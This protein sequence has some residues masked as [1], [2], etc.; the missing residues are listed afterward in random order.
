MSTSILRRHAPRLTAV[1]VIG[2]AYLMTRLPSLAHT[3][4]SALADRFAFT[5]L[6]LPEVPGPERRDRR[7]VH[8][9]LA[10][11]VGW[12]S[13]VGA[14]VALNDF[15]GD[16]LANDLCY[17]E[18]ATDQVIVAPAPGTGDR[19]A[20]FVIESLALR[21]ARHGTRPERE[22]VVAPMGCLGGDFNE[23]GRTDVLVWYWG[24][25]PVAFLRRAG[26]PAPAAS[27]YAAIDVVPRGAA[28][29]DAR[30]WYTNAATTADVDGDGHVDLVIGNYFADGARV[31]DPDAEGVEEMQDSMSRA[32]NGGRDRILLFA[33][34]T[35]GAEPT[36]SFTDAADAFEAPVGRGWT[37]AVGA[38]DLDGDLLPELYFAND[39]GPDRLLHNLSEPGKVRFA[40]LTGRKTIAMPTSKVLG[41]DS[42]KGMGVDF[43]D[44]NDDGLLDI[45]V[46]N[47]AEEF[48][49]EESHFLFASTGRTDLMAAGVAPY[50]DRS[51]ALGVSRSGWG[52]DTRFGDFDNDGVTEMVQATGFLRGEHDRWPELHE[53]AMANDGV[54]RHASSWP[55]FDHGDDLSGWQHNPFFVRAQDGRYYDIAPD[56][57]LGA[58]YLTRGIATADVDGDGDLD[59]AIANQWE[60]SYL[61]R[62]ESAATGASLG[63]DLRIP[64][65]DAS[66]GRPAIGAAVTVRRPDGRALVAQVD[67]GNGHSGARSPEL[68]FGLGALPAGETVMVEV[69]WRDGA[70]GIR[71]RS[72][73]LAPGR[74]RIMLGEDAP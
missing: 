45:Y 20:P 59:F 52:W 68:H 54:V 7:D 69:R 23:D 1:A 56:I 12:I 42:F 48:A 38:A 40:T 63:L 6:P 67:G 64:V 57:G 5:G 10:H 72:F 39:F 11:H 32:F 27:A 33:A 36:V 66:T 8:P 51:E 24:Q 49:L 18:T 37:L 74:H 21:S 26:T 30:R 50:V 55:R 61:F 58:P 15:D 3:E 29:E 22:R 53:L 35:T 4:R 13:V 2:A 17:V 19:Y 46:S 25:P 70:G 71:A 34:A 14:S 43:A 31:L 9:S 41:R 44:V 65:A 16:G 28:S 73:S 47:I 62:N 60:T